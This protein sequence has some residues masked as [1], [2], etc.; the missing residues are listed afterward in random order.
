MAMKIAMFGHKQI[1]SRNGGVEVAVTE[2]STRMAALGHGVTCYNRGGKPGQYEGVSLRGVP[3]LPW[4]GVN[5]VVSGFFAALCS[6]LGDAQVVHIHGVG[7]AF[8][9]P[10]PKLFGKRVVVTVHG[11]D[12]QREK[13][14][15]TLGKWFIRTGEKMAVRFA[16]ELIVLSRNAQEYFA[17]NYGRETVW[18]PNGVALPPA[19]EPEICAR[20]GLEKD[21]Y[22][23]FLG[24][25]VPEKGIHYLLEAFRAVKTEKK[26]VIAGASSDTDAY[27]SRLKAMAREDDRVIFAG[28]VEGRLL[29]ELYGSAYLY[30]LPSDVEGMP[31]TL[32]EALGCG[33]CCVVSDIPECTEVTGD[34][35][36]VFPKGNVGELTA[37]LQRLCGDAA[38]VADYREK[39][40]SCSLPDWD[41]V[42]KM[43]LQV[44]GGNAP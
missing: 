29:A 32:L 5:A 7:P 15:G 38:L 13:W 31:L 43:T 44:Y 2:L 4:K 12:W 30:V 14:R 3:T 24:R 21:G 10:M 25:L 34:C 20:L 8:F 6:A 28:A 19:G 22:L 33:C 26:L 42:T 1:P 27:V 23:L 17:E 41:K 35:A 18:I 11:L 9:C 40:L 37:C 16:D 36:V 39:A